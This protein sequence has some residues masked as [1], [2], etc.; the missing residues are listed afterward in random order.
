MP[1][2]AMPV[3]FSL[4]CIDDGTLDTVIECQECGHSE[5]FKSESVCRNGQVNWPVVYRVW[6]CKCLEG[7]T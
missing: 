2:V 1:R 5:R 3:G 6:A 7:L 4:A